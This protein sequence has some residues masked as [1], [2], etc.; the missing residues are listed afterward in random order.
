MARIIAGEAGSL[1]LTVP[2]GPTRPT[3]DRVREAIFSALGH[4]IDFSGIGVLDLFAGSGALGFEALSRGASSLIAVD[5]DRRA[6]RA[7]NTNK[8][9]VTKALSRDVDVSI[10]QQTVGSFIEQHSDLEGI[11]L[12]FID[13][14]YAVGN[15]ELEALLGSLVTGLADDAVI[16]VERSAKDP[17]PKWPSGWDCVSE[18]TYGDTAVFTLE[19]SR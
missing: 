18:K 14:P 17:A 10:R 2:Q 7:L 13:P 1:S 12:V 16:V 6:A 9:S 4:R 3:S 5:N 15:A 11:A 8:A 19:A